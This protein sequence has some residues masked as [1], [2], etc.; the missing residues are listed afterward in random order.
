MSA[1]AQSILAQLKVKKVIS[2]Q[3]NVPLKYAKQQAVQIKT[4]VV[5]KRSTA[6]IN[7]TEIMAKLGY[8]PTVQSEITTAEKIAEEKKFEELKLKKKEK[9]KVQIIKEKEDEDEDEDDEE[10]LLAALEDTTKPKKSINVSIKKKTP[11]VKPDDE[12]EDD[13]EALLAALEGTTKPKKSINVS[14]K[15]TPLVKPDHT[16]ISVGK[17]DISGFL[18]KLPKKLP[19]I[20]IRAPRLAYYLNNREI[21]VNFINSLLHPYKEELEKSE[22]NITC[23]SKD[24]QEFSL[25]THQEIVRDYINLLTPYRGLLFYH[26]LGSGK[27]CS[28]IAVTEGLKSDKQVIIM[29]PASLEVNYKEELKKCGDLLYKKNQYWEFINTT[30]DPSLIEPLAYILSLSPKNI[31]ENGGAWFVN[32]KNAP[33]YSNLSGE[34][35]ESLNKQ[36]NLMMD[37]KYKFIR[38]NGLRQKALDVLV[39]EA[40]GNPFSN[41]IIVIDEAHNFISLI[42]NKLKQ[43]TSWWIQIYDYLKSAENVKII[44]LTGTPIIN[45]P[46]EIGIMMNILRGNIRTWNF[47]LVN[48]GDYKLTQ[49][50]LLVLFKSNSI[51][52]HIL[53]YLQ[54][55]STPEPTLMIT[56]NP[57]GFYSTYLDSGEYGGVKEGDNGN[58]DDNTFIELITEI[59]LNK[60]IKIVPASTSVKEYTCL[61]DTLTEFSARYIEPA[62][63]KNPITIKNM[64]GFKRRILG[65]VSYFP[66]ID[67]LLPT[68]NKYEYFDIIMIPMSDF[69]FSVYEE[70]RVQERKIES[71]NAKRRAKKGTNNNGEIYEDAVSTYR[72]FSRAFCNFVFPRPD[73]VRPLPNNG[74]T[75][76]SVIT[77]TASED[78]LDAI[79]V[80]EKIRMKTGASTNGMNITELANE[81]D[82]I[83]QLTP[84]AV[85]KN[86]NYANRIVQALKELEINKEQYLNPVALETYSPKFLNILSRILDAEN[87][88]LH[89]IYSSFRTLEGIGILALVLKANGF[90]QFEIKKVGKEWKLNIQPEDMDKPKY[91]LY[92]GT[93]NA[94]EKEIMR[95]IFNSNW[96]LIPTSLRKEILV[97]FPNVEGDNDNRDNLSGKIIKV[98]MITASGAEGISLNN[99]RYVHITEPYWHPVR[100]DQVIG[101]ARRICS[102]KNLDKKYWTVNVFLYL[103]E[104]SKA[105]LKSDLAREAKIHDKSKIEADKIFTS[106][107]ALFE[108]ASQK[109]II[110]HV[111]LHNIKEA[112]IDCN[113]HKKLGSKD[114]LT[115]FTFGSVN[116][117]KF[118]YA[119]SI[120]SSIAD[121]D[122]SND[123]EVVIRKLKNI[124]LN[125][126][127]FAVNVANIS[128]INQDKNGIIQAELYPL[129]S[130]ISKNPIQI[131]IVYFKNLQADDFMFF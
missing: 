123:Q 20:K 24:G 28:S 95:N 10:A 100:I 73:I 111:I 84:E 33:N 124:T 35:Q 30:T 125:G 67:A 119:P 70:A 101:R 48:E 91:I 41:K 15:K 127:K 21:F 18:S 34:K 96:Q 74:E 57:Y 97:Q 6:Q 92:T 9:E 39:A 106:D 103:M 116:P 78:I 77:E 11:L 80:E 1:T 94:E 36:L 55:K 102:H 40:G 60:K 59:L 25:L 61:P 104:F 105:Q 89:L 3:K 26:G 56:R 37:N 75:I 45:Y 31:I 4:A 47:Q 52:N 51:A 109:E 14:I 27:T 98:I 53:D 44:L 90:A 69:Q 126:R 7:R 12:D 19:D 76:A 81:E 50:T 114:N 121:K 63:L 115:C 85:K 49:D 58:I 122:R 17:P 112:S 117:S 16:V 128:K 108:I 23:E 8:T 29:T 46:N 42:V 93:E 2:P 65:L 82:L 130:I 71:N 86:A 99:V 64:D 118:A 131:G 107:Q 32:V 62:S 54:Y 110:N 88:G 68:Y 120:T 66:D 79:S 22:A 83:E 113:I 5:D 72:I 43:P 87:F 13:E 129:N 38:Y